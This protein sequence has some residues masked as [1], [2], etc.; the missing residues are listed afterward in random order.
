MEENKTSIGSVIA[1]I[2][3]IALIVLGGLYFWGKRI[4]QTQSV[5]TFTVATTTTTI[6]EPTIINLNA[7]TSSD[8]VS[9]STQIRL[10]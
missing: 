8:I 1:T 6:T 7:T 5:Q 3:I 4:E 2:I 9:S 10:D